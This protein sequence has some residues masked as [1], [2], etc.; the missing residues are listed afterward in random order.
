MSPSKLIEKDWVRFKS[1]IR[2]IP[3]GVGVVKRRVLMEV[4]ERVCEI[5][6]YSERE[7]TGC[8]ARIL[9]PTQ[10]D[11]DYVGTEKYRQIE[12]MGIGTVETRWRKK[13][14][15]IIHVLL[16]STP[17][18][19]KAPSEGMTF[20]VMDIT[21]RKRAE[22]LLRIQHDLAIALG[23][24]GTL[25]SAMEGLMSAVTQIE[26]VDCGGL[27]LVDPMTGEVDLMTS[28]G[29]S[30][31]FIDRVSHFDPDAQEAEL[32]MSGNPLFVPYSVILNSSPDDIRHKEGLKALA[33]IPLRHEGKVIAALNLGSHAGEEFSLES[34]TTIEAVAAQVGS[35]LARVT[36]E[37]RLKDERG[38]FIAGPVVVVKWQNA[39]NWP[40]EYI[41]PNVAALLGYRAN[42][43]LNGVLN[44]TH[45]IHPDDLDQVVKGVEANIKA[46]RR[47]YEQEYRMTRSDGEYRWIHDFT[48]VIYDHSGKLTHFHGYIHDITERRNAEEDRRKLELS[49]QHAQKL[50][51]L[52]VLAGG[53]AHDFNNLLMSILGNLDL[54][55]DE[56]PASSSIRENLQAAEKASLRAA[57]LC[58]QMLAYSGR[59]KFVVEAVDLGEMVEE[60]A[61]MLDVSIPKK[62][63]MTY[64][65][66]PNLPTID[67]DATQIRQVVMNLVM[68]ASEAIGNKT[69]VIA[70][71]IKLQKTGKKELVGDLFGDT[72]SECSH[73]CL[74]VKDNGCGMDKQTIS[75][76]FDPFFST[77]VTGR[78][79]GL[80]AV[81][82]IVKAHHGAIRV[83]SEPDKGS[84]F[85]VF[86]PVGK[87]HVA[88]RIQDGVEADADWRGRGTVLIVD[89]EEWILDV[90]RNMLERIGF[91]VLSTGDPSQ[92]IEIFRKHKGEIKCVMLDIVMPQMSGEELLNQLREVDDS[93]RAVMMS[94]YTESEL[95][96]RVGEKGLMGFIQKPFDITAMKKVMMSI[97]D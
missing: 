79:L 60:M 69:G 33:V 65:C 52:G 47:W 22:A 42:D 29:L 36:A 8:H 24:A 54:A 6:G 3:M 39:E 71:A 50:E 28:T 76:I 87:M 68:N 72:L 92:A 83:S 43:F 73:I 32:V 45:L 35:L 75:R 89:D 86:F 40:V 5:T 84:A 2:A 61:R 10:E 74:E 88:R 91:Q 62:I 11:Y 56:L 46:G 19:P 25:E 94:G 13:D 93:V 85:S 37:S 34:R 38:L 17:L 18:N 48:K 63:A 77:K 41:S 27:Y 30:K 44:Y 58:K 49:M 14:G 26:G 64:H 67:A 20:T 82:G 57:D 51:S 21:S 90:S 78:G 97:A 81:L 16:S 96:G 66:A 12:E 53:I 15:S 95:S 23:S 59:S 80:A 1:I 70:I 7:L 31:A 9:Y 55:L 4:N